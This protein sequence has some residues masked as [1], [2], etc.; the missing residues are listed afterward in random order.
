MGDLHTVEKPC[1]W[2]AGRPLNGKKT[3]GARDMTWGLWDL[4]VTMATDGY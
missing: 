3:T 4:A 2:A 1:R